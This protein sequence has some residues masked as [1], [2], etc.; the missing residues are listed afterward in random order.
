MKRFSLNKETMERTAKKV[1]SA[2]LCITPLAE[3]RMLNRILF[4]SLG[5]VAGSETPPA[6]SV[7]LEI[8]QWN[9]VFTFRNIPKETLEY[10]LKNV[11]TGSVASYFG[12]GSFTAGIPINDDLSKQIHFRLDPL[13][14]NRI[15]GTVYSY[16][17]PSPQKLLAAFDRTINAPSYMIRVGKTIVYAEEPGYGKRAGVLAREIDAIRKIL[18][19][20]DTLPVTLKGYNRKDDYEK[21]LSKGMG[22]QNSPRL[23]WGSV[24][25]LEDGIRITASPFH[26]M[27]H[28][29]FDSMDSTAQGRVQK[30]YLK[31]MG[32]TDVRPYPNFNLFG[33]SAYI[34]KHPLVSLFDESTYVKDTVAFSNYGHPYSN[35]SELLASG[36]SVLRFFYPQYKAK[37]AALEKADPH[38]ASLAHEV[39]REMRRA[40]KNSD[41]LNR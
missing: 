3:R 21:G 26:E 17:Y 18:P 28:A 27:I 14:P 9:A 16:S 6:P 34:E 10:D 22:Y 8:V 35:E 2:F 11:T 13:K 4:L 15:V 41:L 31:M 32:A 40:L 29:Y 23:V 5:A 12:G 36:C 30:V 20:G 33:P 25:V 37:L 1:R 24:G 7:S 38:L 39:E 19:C